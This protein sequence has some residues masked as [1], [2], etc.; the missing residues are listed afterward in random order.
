MKT[1]QLPHHQNQEATHGFLHSY[2]DSFEIFENI[3][4]CVCVSG[5]ITGWDWKGVGSRCDTRPPW[6]WM[7]LIRAT[8]ENEGWRIWMVAS[9]ICCPSCHK[10]ERDKGMGQLW[11]GWMIITNSPNKPTPFPLHLDLSYWWGEGKKNTQTNLLECIIS[12]KKKQGIKLCNP[13]PTKQNKQW[14]SKQKPLPNGLW[15]C[16]TW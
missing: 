11:K 1:P 6:T 4:V 8:L 14:K 15:Y 16:C 9:S 2:S 10:R 5:M 3:C 12:E 7:L 13:K